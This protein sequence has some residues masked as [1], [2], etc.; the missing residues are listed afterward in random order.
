MR[1]KIPRLPVL[2]DAG[3]ITFFQGGSK[4]RRKGQKQFAALFKN[5]VAFTAA[6]VDPDGE[7][8]V[9]HKNSGLS[10]VFGTLGTSV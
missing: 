9:H 8:A 4:Q 2:V 7:I 10:L 3:K 1:R 6:T 5:R